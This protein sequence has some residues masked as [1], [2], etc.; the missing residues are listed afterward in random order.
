VK[1]ILT[2]LGLLSLP[3]IGCV[4]SNELKLSEIGPSHYA[5]SQQKLP[6]TG[7]LIVYSAL[8]TVGGLD[9]DHPRHTSYSIL[10]DE[11]QQL[12]HVRN[13]VSPILDDPIAVSLSPGKYLV[14]ARVQ[15]Y[16]MITVPVL[17]EAGRNTTLY[18]DDSTGPNLGGI[19]PADLEKLPDGRVVGWRAKKN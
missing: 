11:G 18:L 6:P 9:S 5:R 14:K 8:E 4:A 15:G 1:T 12:R 10:S 2:I 13:Y 17:I 7:T 19:D 16:G 3:L